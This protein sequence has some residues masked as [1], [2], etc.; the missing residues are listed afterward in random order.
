MSTTKRKFN[1]E[2]K[3][4][5][6]LAWWKDDETLESLANKYNLTPIQISICRSLAMKNLGNAFIPESFH[7]NESDIYTHII[8]AQ[9]GQL[10]VEN[11]FL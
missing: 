10:K 2:F 9:L 3:S 5:M 4:K 1:K 6:V 8:Y 11:K 7:V